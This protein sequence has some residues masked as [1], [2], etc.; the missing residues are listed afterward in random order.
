MSKVFHPNVYANGALLL[1]CEIRSVANP[2]LPVWWVTSSPLCRLHLPRH[3]SES[4]EP[5]L[6][7]RRHPDL[8]P[9][10]AQ[11]PQPQLAGANPFD[12]RRKGRP[13]DCLHLHL[14]T[15]RCQPHDERVTCVCQLTLFKCVRAC[16]RA[17]D[18]C[19]GKRGGGANVA[20]ESPRVREESAGGCRA[21]LGLMMISLRQDYS[22]PVIIH[23]ALWHVTQRTC[24]SHIHTC[25]TIPK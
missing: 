21:E 23:S 13:T 15:L 10:A 17:F 24:E 18:G 9:V 16:V 1:V 11:R 22:S 6:R 4:V 12:S 3:T 20:R 14:L 25:S 19:S 5:D 2:C 7:H 8:D